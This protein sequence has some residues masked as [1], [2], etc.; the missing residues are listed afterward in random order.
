MSSWGTTFTLKSL[1]KLSTS[2]NSNEN[3]LFKVN[4]GKTGYKIS[5]ESDEI[6]FFYYHEGLIEI[7]FIVCS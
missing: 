4:L 7:L 1:S 6:I 3:L 5:L 2:L